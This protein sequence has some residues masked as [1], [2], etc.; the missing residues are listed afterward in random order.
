[1]QL[2][3]EFDLSPACMSAAGRRSRPAASSG[4]WRRT[5]STAGSMSCTATTSRRKRSRR[6][7]E[8][9]GTFTVTAEIELQMGYG[10]PLTGFCRAGLADRDRHRRRACGRQRSVH[11]MRITLQ[12]ERNRGI[13]ETLASTGAGP[14]ERRSPAGMRCHGSPPMPPRSQASRIAPARSRPASRPTLCC[15][16]RP[17]SGADARSGRLCGDAG[18]HR[19]VDTVLIAGR[20]VKRGGQLLHGGLAEKMAP[21]NAPGSVFA[22]NF[23]VLPGAAQASAVTSGGRGTSRSAVRC[24]WLSRASVKSSPQRQARRRSRQP[25]RS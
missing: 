20:V 9:G 24:H 13:I 3:R 23:S 16:P 7:V 19:N 1:M 10:D 2:A 17:Q 11:R 4:C 5:W 6:M 15:A 25:R 8:R 21:C 12:H 14:D 18:G 22:D